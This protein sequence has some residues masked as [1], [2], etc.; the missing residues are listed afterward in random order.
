LALGRYA[1]FF[2][3][4]GTDEGA[5]LG[6]GA[7]APP[8]N[9]IKKCLDHSCFYPRH[10]NREL[11]YQLNGSVIVRG[12]T[13]EMTEICDDVICLFRFA[14]VAL[15]FENHKNI[16]WYGFFFVF[17]RWGMGLTT[18]SLLFSFSTILFFSVTI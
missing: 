18:L 17:G 3:S 14:A 13:L 1:I 11:K 9:G 4:G 7:N 10:D 6:G 16:I 15:H 8:V 2:F 12:N 5:Q